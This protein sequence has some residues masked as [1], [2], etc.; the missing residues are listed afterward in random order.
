MKKAAFPKERGFQKSDLAD[1]GTRFSRNRP[2]RLSDR[3]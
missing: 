1:G 3:D 2:E